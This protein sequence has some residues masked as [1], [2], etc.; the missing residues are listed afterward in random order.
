MSVLF[1]KRAPQLTTK[2]V[3]E[4]FVCEALVEKLIE[5]GAQPPVDLIPLL[6]YVPEWMGASWK[7]LCRDIRRLQRGLNFGLLSEMEERNARGDYNGS[8]MEV[9]SGRAKEWGLDREMIG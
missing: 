4:F 7:G 8:C 3:T 9:I 2:E 6:K 5:P 1:G